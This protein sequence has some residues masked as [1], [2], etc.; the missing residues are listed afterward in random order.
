MFDSQKKLRLL[1]T[2]V[3]TSKVL[4]QLKQAPAQLART[5][6]HGEWRKPDMSLGAGLAKIKKDFPAS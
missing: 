1:H 2:F 6:Y 5:R 3:M 4:D